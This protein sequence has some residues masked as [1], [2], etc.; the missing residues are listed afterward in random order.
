MQYSLDKHAMAPCKSSSRPALALLQTIYHS[1]SL[2][3]PQNGPK[4]VVELLYRI[5]IMELANQHGRL[6]D[7]LNCAQSSPLVRKRDS[8]LRCADAVQLGGEI[9]LQ[10]SKSSSETAIHVRSHLANESNRLGWMI[11]EV[12]VLWEDAT[13]ESFVA[14]KPLEFC[15]RGAE[16]CFTKLFRIFQKTT[17]KQG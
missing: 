1:P 9:A 7:N 4:I 3:S 10:N 8:V 15:H 16:F 2:Q 12:F 13:G 6:F 11:R 17:V 14:A 5:S